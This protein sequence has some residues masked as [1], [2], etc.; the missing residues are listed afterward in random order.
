MYAQHMLKERLQILVT[1]EQ[2]RGLEAEARRRGVSVASLI[3]EAIE[4]RFP[5]ATREDRTR[6]LEAIRGMRGRFLPPGELDRLADTERDESFPAGH[7]S[8]RR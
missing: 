1:P 2:R 4:A 5:I 3:R 7:R 8:R 6:A